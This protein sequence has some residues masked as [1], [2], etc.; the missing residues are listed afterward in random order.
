MNERMQNI[1]QIV[2]LQS[3]HLHSKF[4]QLHKLCQFGDL[5]HLPVPFLHVKPSLAYIKKTATDSSSQSVQPTV[6]QK[7]LNLK[8]G[9]IASYYSEESNEIKRLLS[10]IKSPK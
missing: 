8:D 9:K 2:S 6:S 10:G 5:V 1:I 7:D 4:D 3:A